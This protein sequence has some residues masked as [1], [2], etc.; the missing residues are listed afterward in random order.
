MMTNSWSILLPSF[1]FTTAYAAI[2]N[3][4]GSGDYYSSFPTDVTSWS[5]EEA[6]SNVAALSKSKHRNVVPNIVV[7]LG[8][9]DIFEALMA[10]DNGS[11]YGMANSTVRL[12]FSIDEFVP[13]I[14][15]SGT[16]WQKEWIWPR[17]RAICEN[18]LDC[19]GK[20]LSDLHN[21]RPTS[22]LSKLV[23]DSKYFASCDLLNHGGGCMSPAEDGSNTTCSCN[24]AYQPPESQRGEI[25]RI[26]MYMDVRYD[27]T[28]EDS[29]DLRLADCPFNAPYDFAYLSQMIKWHN[30]YPPSEQEKMRN[31]LVCTD[32]QG[33]RNPFVDYPA[34]V[35][36]IFGEPLPDPAAGR[37]NYEVCDEL[38]TSSPTFAPNECDMIAP[39]DI[40][41]FMVNSD[42]GPD[43]VAFW[44]YEEIP[45]ELELFL[46]DRPW[47]GSSFIGGANNE[48]GTI[49]L[50][51]PS[52]GID[53]ETIIGFGAGK[54]GGSWAPEEGTF[55]LAPNGEQIFLY[56]MGAL[57]GPVPL[58]SIAYGPT[59]SQ[60][61]VADRLKDRGAVIIEGPFPNWIYN[62]PTDTLEKLQLQEA[63]KDPAN[64]NGG[65]GRAT[66]TSSANS[67]G[68][69][70]AF[71]GLFAGAVLI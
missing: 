7:P 60:N 46:T 1:L 54:L 63:S 19:V 43:E 6:R 2:Y 9:N 66:L 35:S 55:S 34:L 49:K 50:V 11:M 16:G 28:E 10:L 64:W 15:F 59:A 45:G 41:F 47:D 68:L 71:L 17:R 14:P 32:Y 33:N 56:C 8:E 22:Q 31:E 30:Q 44:N 53:G 51:V 38:T 69:T 52:E 67:V 65:E 27:G 57:G 25:A 3:D 58:A 70:F 39:G 29:E 4:C 40:V 48:E 36:V 23:R 5:Q 20:D 18:S 24:R 61:T 26:L 12:L 21:V 42:G 13:A 37:E 62:G